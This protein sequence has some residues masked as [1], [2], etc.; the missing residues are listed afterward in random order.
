[1]QAII[2]FA[3]PVVPGGILLVNFTVAPG[4]PQSVAI[5]LLT[6]VTDNFIT[7]LTVVGPPLVTGDR[8]NLHIP[9]IE[10]G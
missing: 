10:P 5:L 9:I 3:M 4:D 1:M 8:A 7:N 6:R 2:N